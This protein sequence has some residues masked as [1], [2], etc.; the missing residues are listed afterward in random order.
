MNRP[1]LF[2][3][4]G[5]VAWVTSLALSAEPQYAKPIRKDTPTFTRD[6]API[7]YKNCIGCHRRGEVA[8]MSLLTYADA[9]PWAK[10]IRDEVTEGNMPPWHADPQ[11]LRLRGDRRLNAEDKEILV[12]WANGGAPEGDP[13]A[14]PLAPSFTQGWRF[15][16]PDAILEMQE[17]Y[18]IPAEGTIDYAWFY[19]PTNFTEAKWVQAIEMRPGNPGVVHHLLVYYRAAPDKQRQPVLQ[20]NRELMKTAERAP[21]PR[22]PKARELPPRRLIATF[23]PGVDP[24]VFPPGTALRLEPAGTLELQIH[25]TANGTAGTDRSKVGLTFAREEPKQ[26]IRASAFYNGTLVLPP[27]ADGVMIDAEVSFVQDGIVWGMLPHTH[28]RGKKWEYRLVRPDGTTQM[29]LAVPRYDFNWQNF[30]MFEEPLRV[31]KGSKIISSAWYDN[32]AK[33]PFNPD[34]KIQVLWGDQT[35]EE[36][37]YTGLLFSA[38]PP[39]PIPTR[40]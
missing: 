35:W 38:A 18:P 28:L 8:P 13:A 9:R 27:G 32:S 1:F 4:A 15:G 19:I 37:Q 17:D 6:V 29:I 5:T 36:M 12:R 2:L 31:P 24:Q 33:N 14:L 25:Y 23:G 3:G 11:Y 39:A 7:L 26:E 20:F 30:Y 10:A 21:G 16:K 34:P 22:P 40:R